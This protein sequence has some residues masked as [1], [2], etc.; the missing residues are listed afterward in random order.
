MFSGGGTDA[1]PFQAEGPQVIS[2]AFPVR[3]TH[4]AVEI[5]GES[6]LNRTI[7]LVCALAEHYG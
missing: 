7:D 6:D 3:Y 2:L 4:S 1:K 5:A